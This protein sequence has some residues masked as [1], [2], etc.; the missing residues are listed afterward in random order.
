M[1]SLAGLVAFVKTAETGSFTKAARQLGI[2][3]AAVSKSV[4]RL[5]DQMQA[6]LFNRTTR[7]LGLTEEGQMLLERCKN[8]MSE[9]ESA[10]RALAEHRSTPMGNLRVSCAQNFGHLKLLPLVPVFLARYPQITLDL[11]L[12]DHVADLVGEGYDVAIR[13]GR[14]PDSDMVARRIFS[15]RLGLY[16]SHRYLER[17]GEPKTLDQLAHHNCLRFRYTSSKRLFDWEFQH[18]SETLAAEIDGNLIVNDPGALVRLCA[19]DLGISVLA[20]FMVAGAPYATELKRILPNVRIPERG[21]Y[22]CYASRK[23][24]PLK[25]KAFVDFLADALTAE[26]VRR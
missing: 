8:P 15:M 7:Q 3:P 25:V 1:Q 4:Q 10:S 21:F 20:D 13:G 6:R 14:L 11:T 16:A 23:H 19:A 18:G 22:A 5:E 17:Y 9:L 24:T 26:T 12:D 2:T